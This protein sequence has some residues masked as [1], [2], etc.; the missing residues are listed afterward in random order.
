MLQ[1]M[2][3]VEFVGFPE[4]PQIMGALGAALFAAEKAPE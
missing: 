3:N 1:E 4:D 2:L